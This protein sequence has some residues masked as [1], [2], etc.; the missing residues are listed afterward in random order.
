MMNERGEIPVEIVHLYAYDVGR[1]IDLNKVASLVPAHRDIAL[2]KRRD[3]PA[4]LTLPKPL[5]LSISTEE[6]DSKQFSKISA[7][8]KIYEDG[9]ITV[10]VRYCTLSTFEGLPAKAHMLIR[11][12]SGSSSIEQFAESSFRMVR[13]ALRSAIVGYKELS[14]SDRETYIAFCL[15]ECPGGDPQA[16]INAHKDMAA[17]LISGETAGTLHISQIEQ[18]LDKSFSYRRND[19]AIFDLDR[20][21]IIDP[22]ADYDDVLMMAEHA[23]YRLIELRELDF[24]LDEWLSEA[25]R[26]I[27]R[28]YFSG[29]RK[30]SSERALRLKLAQIQGLRFDA[31]FTLE[32]LDNSSKIIGDYFLGSIYHRL[33]EIF[34]TD[35][36]KFSV[37]RRL[38]ALQNIYELL[39]SDTTEQRMMTLE[40]V[41]I[42]VCIIFPILQIIQVMLVK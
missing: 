19:I 38:N 13:E 39:K 16:F 6:C 18:I 34:N 30:R 12:V 24:L 20:C 41:F 8:A 14:E 32:N 23:N 3:T 22:S 37:E 9:A 36:W 17:S 2:A 42:A 7:M 26:D 35:E 31:L 11:D 33:C 27:R 25:E 4:Y 10:I 1:S 5:V 28:L 40:M 15:L 29:R 21:L